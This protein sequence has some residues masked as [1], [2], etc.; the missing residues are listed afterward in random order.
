[1]VDRY[2]NKMLQSLTSHHWQI[3]FLTEHHKKNQRRID[4][5][6]KE[7]EKIKAIQ[8]NNKG[9]QTAY[10]LI[11]SFIPVLFTILGVLYYI[12]KHLHSKIILS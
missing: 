8:Q 12:I 5:L 11:F 7:I 1:M 10:L 4:E 3:K 2:R 9:R 6:N